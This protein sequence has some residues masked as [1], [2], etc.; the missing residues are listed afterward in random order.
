MC[1]TI[2]DS[3]TSIRDY[4]FFGCSNLTSITIPNSVTSIGNSA[5]TKCPIEV[6]TIPTIACKAVISDKLKKVIIT[7]GT[8]IEDY[9]FHGCTSLINITI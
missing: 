2:P 5:F 1:V 6:A 9:A 7:G 8:R 3:V 4:A